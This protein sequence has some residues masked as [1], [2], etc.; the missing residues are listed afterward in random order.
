M[1]KIFLFF[2]LIFAISAVNAQNYTPPPYIPPYQILTADSVT[3]TPLNLKKNK[4]VMVIYFQPDCS[5]CEHL[6]YEMKPKMKDFKDIQVVMVT[7]VQLKALKVF[8]RDFDLKKYPNFIV[9]TEGYGLKVQKYYQVKTTPYIA[10]YD[11]NGKLFKAWE[12]APTVDE[13]AESA[14][15][16]GV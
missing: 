1:K 4:P 5:H 2:T 8:Y 16:V 10:L 15:K 12:K 6:M 11:K 14:K 13:L 9:G 7:F 3:V